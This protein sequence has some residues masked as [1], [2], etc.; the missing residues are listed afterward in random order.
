MAVV[1]TLFAG[2]QA[3]LLSGI[4]PEPLPTPSPPVIPTLLL[5]SYGGLSVNVGAALSAMVF[6]NIV[7]EAQ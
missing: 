5:V 6:I 4:P 2:I 3:Q 1:T 7:G